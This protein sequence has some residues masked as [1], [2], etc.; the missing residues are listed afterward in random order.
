[1]PCGLWL[2]PYTI[3]ALPTTVRGILASPFAAGDGPPVTRSTVKF[4]AVK[5]VFSTPFIALFEDVR[6]GVGSTRDEAA[7]QVSLLNDRGMKIARLAS[8]CMIARSSN[9]LSWLGQEGEKGIH[10]FVMGVV[11]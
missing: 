4:H 9:A 1:M 11:L 8:V 6:N 2:M 3:R 10:G 5:T 7:F